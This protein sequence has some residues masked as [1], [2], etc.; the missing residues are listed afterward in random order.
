M[1]LRGHLI[2]GM[3]IIDYPYDSLFTFLHCC[4]TV[5][6][7]TN[8]CLVYLCRDASIKSTSFPLGTFM[9]QNIVVNVRFQFDWSLILECIVRHSQRR[10]KHIVDY[11]L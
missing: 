9:I 1:S 7:K 3:A 11:I 2:Y 5:S 4:R 6:L 8:V 10:F